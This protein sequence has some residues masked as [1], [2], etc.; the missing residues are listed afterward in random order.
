MRPTLQK[1]NLD[2]DPPAPDPTLAEKI[3]L[4]RSLS[5]AIDLYKARK[6]LNDVASVIQ[7]QSFPDRL[8]PHQFQRLVKQQ[9]DT[10]HLDQRKRQFRETDPS[11]LYQGI[12]YE[13]I[14][15]LLA[16]DPSIASVLNIGCNYAYMDWLLAK[17]HEKVDFRA[18]DVNPGL[19]EI[20]ADL[21]LKNT[22]FY[23]GYALELIERGKVTADL[24][25][26][27][28]AS[29]VIRNEELRTYAKL[30]AARAKYYL[31]SEP[32]WTLP[33]GEIID[34]KTV[35]PLESVPAFLQREPLTGD[36]GYLC[37]I[38]NYRAIMEEV[39]FEAIEYRF[40]KPDIGPHHWCVVLGQNTNTDR[41]T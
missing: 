21:K 7:L 40:Y 19:V 33:G 8:S 34:P 26:T 2:M 3:E 24:I 11:R 29:T 1:S 18:I 13:I 23:S 35:H 9:E 22:T 28:S 38:H 31:I 4:G 37:W 39:G 20:N 10:L 41:W 25:Y 27:S 5:E 6:E 32:V 16:A 36:F 30:I 14:R 15:K 17:D 12:A